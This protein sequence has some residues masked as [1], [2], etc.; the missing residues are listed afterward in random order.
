MGYKGT[1]QRFDT[2]GII[3]VEQH[4]L[5]RK[6]NRMGSD[7]VGI[8]LL[9]DSPIA[10]L[11]VTDRAGATTIKSLVPSGTS[12]SKPSWLSL[13]NSGGPRNQVR[14]RVQSAANGGFDL[15]QTSD[16][17][18]QWSVEV[19]VT[20]EAT[21]SFPGGGTFA[22]TGGGMRFVVG[23]SQGPSGARRATLSV[24]TNG[25]AVGEHGSSWAPDRVEYST[26]INSLSQVVATLDA[27]GTYRIYLNGAQ[28]ATGTA[29]I[30]AIY[31]PKTFGGLSFGSYEGYVSHVALYNFALSAAQISN[32]YAARL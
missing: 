31:V 23:G 13:G 29:S 17:S 18:Q 16:P 14:G 6:G 12:Y 30:S 24:G 25:I 1:D 19:W 8:A 26:T 28:V 20:P 15:T 32:H 21:T 9:K 7:R 22:M 11:G 3:P 2:R 10:Y 4:Y 5:E 27:G